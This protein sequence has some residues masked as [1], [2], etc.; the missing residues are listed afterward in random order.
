MTL[1]DYTFL[2]KANDKYEDELDEN[3]FSP[4]AEEILDQMTVYCLNHNISA[5]EFNKYFN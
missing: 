3:G 4:Y 5:Q 1:K 2:R